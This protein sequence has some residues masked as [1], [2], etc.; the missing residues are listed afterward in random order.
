M[1]YVAYKIRWVILFGIFVTTANRQMTVSS[2][3][4]QNSDLARYFHASP[5]QIDV[6]SVGDSIVAT[7]T[8]LCLSVIGRHVGIRISSLMVGCA[9]TLGNLLVSIG[10]I[11]R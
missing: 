8:C 7:L 9:A 11:T 10:F 3:G 6:L 2:F 4:L 1:A 5:Y